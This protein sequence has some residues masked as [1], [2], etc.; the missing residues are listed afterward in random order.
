M[1]AIS[2][3]S[4]GGLESPFWEWSTLPLFCCLVL[5][6]SNLKKK[7]QIFLPCYLSESVD[8]CHGMIF[9]RQLSLKPESL[10]L[11][12]CPVLLPPQLKSKYCCHG[13]IYSDGI[14]AAI[15]IET[16]IVAPGPARKPG[17]LGG[18]PTNQLVCLTTNYV[19]SL[20]QKT[21]ASWWSWSQLMFLATYR[22]CKAGHGLGSGP[23]KPSQVQAKSGS[24][25]HFQLENLSSRASQ[26]WQAALLPRN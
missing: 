10:P 25:T 13:M 24:Q 4:G 22:W 5:L 7:K 26:A 18:W 1:I 8:Y 9:L 21:A 12:C 19:R 14:L 3:E 15:I 23:G 11:Y 20:L 6:L 2:S 16:S 17:L